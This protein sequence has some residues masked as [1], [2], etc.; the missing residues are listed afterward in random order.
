MTSVTRIARLWDEESRGEGH[1]E[2]TNQDLSSCF[3]GAFG[4]DVMKKDT[5]AIRNLH[6]GAQI[7][8]RQAGSRADLFKETDENGTTACCI[9]TAK[10][11][12]LTKRGRGIICAHKSGSSA[13]TATDHRRTHIR[14]ICTHRSGSSAHTHQNTNPKLLCGLGWGGVGWGGVGWGGDS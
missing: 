11:G 10:T 5:P 2:A 1:G 6:Q 13:H 8:S 14:I 12:H 4:G 7:I 9:P 3:G